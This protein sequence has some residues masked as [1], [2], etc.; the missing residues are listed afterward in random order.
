MYSN[1]H[2]VILT[3]DCCCVH[4]L[5]LWAAQ[6]MEGTV[7]YTMGGRS[8][9]IDSLSS[10]PALFTSYSSRASMGMLQKQ[11]SLASFSDTR[12][13]QDKP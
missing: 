2:A 5:A 12:A 3:F 9:C 11:L 6:H 7:G 1:A 13:W 8:P 10:L 4:G